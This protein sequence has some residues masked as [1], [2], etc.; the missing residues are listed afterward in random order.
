MAKTDAP[1]KSTYDVVII[2]G[3][4]TATSATAWF[5]T[6]MEDFTGSVLVVERDPSYEFA[7]TSL[8]NSSIRQQFSTELNVKISQFGAEF[9][10]NLPKYMGGEAPKLKIRNFGY[11][12]LAADEVFAGVLRAQQEVQVAVGAETP[13]S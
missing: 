5:L 9:S 11:M 10:Q 3:R 8:S 12:Y 4:I 13:G 1:K 7:A 6:E 2:P